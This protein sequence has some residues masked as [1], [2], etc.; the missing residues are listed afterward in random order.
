MT[1]WKDKNSFYINFFIPLFNL[2]SKYI[3][4]PGHICFNIMPWMYDDLIKLGLPN[5]DMIELRPQSLGQK[6]NL[7]K[8]DKIYIWK[9]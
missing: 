3:K 9:L 6:S 4:K 1:P 5:A 8:Q 2:C 7:E